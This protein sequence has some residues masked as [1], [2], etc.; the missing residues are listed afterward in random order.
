MAYTKAPVTDTHNTVRVPYLGSSF[1][2]TDITNDFPETLNYYNC[3]PLK[4]KQH[5]HDPKY[6][7]SKREPY[8]VAYTVTTNSS[9]LH[10]GSVVVDSNTGY[11]FFAKGDSIYRLRYNSGSPLID[12]VTTST[13]AYSNSAT[14][15]L[16][17][18]GAGEIVFLCDGGKLIKFDPGLVA[19]TTVTPSVGLIPG[20]GLEFIN[21]YLFALGA[22]GFIYNSDP[23]NAL[24]TW[25]STNYINA[26]MYPDVPQAIAK[27]KNH[28]VA[29]GS[30]SIEFFYD[31]AIEIG[32]PL[33][34]QE[35]YT[36]RVGLA[37]FNGNASESIAKIGDDLYFIGRNKTS[38]MALFRIRDFKVEEIDSQY[39][40]GILNTPQASLF[41]RY[42]GGVTTIYVNNNPMVMVRMVDDTN[43][44][45]PVYYPET[46]TWCLFDDSDLGTHYWRIGGMWTS[47]DWGYSGSGRSPFFL[48]R[49]L[50]TPTQ[51]EIRTA[52]TDGAVSLTATY[53]SE[54]IDL[55][56]NFWKHIA[57]VDAVGIYG[58][59][60]LT[61]KYFPNASYTN[62]VAC[63]PTQTPS[64]FGDFNN[65]SWYNLGRYRRFAL[66]IEMAG[67]GPAFHEAFDITYNVGAA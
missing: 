2:V 3:F 13:N 56:I 64:T 62:K 14:E 33:T 1:L 4:E 30:E 54:V 32:S 52:D 24:M 66:Q 53:T 25:N 44:K 57:R 16:T 67:A 9:T 8:K 10:S 65:I 63:T 31:A 18:S 43:A 38:T 5:G 55:G 40:A 36:S 41:D 49:N 58:N 19:V 61:L 21:G 48:T 23:G 20:A 34:R 50:T 45:S 35:N 22:G 46:D 37:A 39:I 59:N 7:V 47:K 6:R 29:F 42:I 17:A 51:V 60:T 15:V 26:E 28:L 11:A 12:T 27:H